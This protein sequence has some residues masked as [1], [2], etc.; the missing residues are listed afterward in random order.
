M[1]VHRL[2]LQKRA[3]QVVLVKVVK[4]KEMPQRARSCGH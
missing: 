1:A 3:L 2:A 4:T